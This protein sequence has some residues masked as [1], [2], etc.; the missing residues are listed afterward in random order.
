MDGHVRVWAIGDQKVIRE[1]RAYWHENSK[2]FEENS[3]PNEIDSM[4]FSPDGK[5]L[6][7]MGFPKGS[8]FTV[9]IWE[10]S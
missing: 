3:A 2:T 5:Y 1:W 8:R 10:Y 7:T 9:R 4:T 6:A